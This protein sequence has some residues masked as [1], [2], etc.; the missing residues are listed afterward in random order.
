MHLPGDA[1][2]LTYP[3]DD[4]SNKMQVL[5]THLP[6][7][8]VSERA[9]CRFW[10]QMTDQAGARAFDAAQEHEWCSM[11]FVSIA[12]PPLPRPRGPPA[13]LA[14]T[15]ESDAACCHQHPWCP[16]AA[17]RTMLSC[18][19]SKQQNEHGK[20]LGLTERKMHRLRCSP[21]PASR[22][23]KRNED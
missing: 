3:R 15:L 1:S 12:V 14:N 20:Q 21:A 8:E 23:S 2:T 6:V 9:R 11:R 7:A 4:L 19:C 5:E 18:R 16:C 17:P 22:T 13:T 10:Y